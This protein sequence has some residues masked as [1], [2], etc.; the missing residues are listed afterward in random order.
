[1][2]RPEAAQQCLQADHDEVSMKASTVSRKATL[3]HRSRL[4]FGPYIP[5]PGHVSFGTEA[6]YRSTRAFPVGRNTS[7]RG[8]HYEEERRTARAALETDA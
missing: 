2:R 1:M 3:R 4:D 6:S 5:A 7:K 8:R